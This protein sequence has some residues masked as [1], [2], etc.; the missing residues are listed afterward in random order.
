MNIQ[1]RLEKCSMRNNIWPNEQDNGHQKV[2]ESL[3]HHF[4]AEPNE[5]PMKVEN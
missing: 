1:Y 4:Y 2:S 5:L 3:S